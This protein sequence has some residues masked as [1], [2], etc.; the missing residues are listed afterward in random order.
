MRTVR[1]LENLTIFQFPQGHIAGGNPQLNPTKILKI[2]EIWTDI[3]PV[4]ND[5]ITISNT[6]IQ[7]PVEGFMYQLVTTM[8]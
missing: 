7:L 5:H 8:K 2:T 3:C 6:T 4:A 1:C